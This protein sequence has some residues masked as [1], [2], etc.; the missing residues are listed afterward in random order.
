ML[1]LIGV[2]VND[3]LVLV[4]YINKKRKEGLE[5]IDSV[6][7]AATTRFRPVILTSITT[8]AGLVPIL[9]D[10]SQQAKWLKPMATSLGFGIMFAT[11]MTLIIVP[12]NYI[13]ARKA[14]Y[15]VI[16]IKNKLWHRWLAFWHNK[17]HMNK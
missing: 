2:L 13:V 8:F 6:I 3:S 12:V 17:P 4:D 7:I 1:A 5:I 14:K 9:L 16:E 15:A 11:I 10:G